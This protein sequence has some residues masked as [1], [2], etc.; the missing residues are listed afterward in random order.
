MLMITS[1]QSTF[2]SEVENGDDDDDA[3]EILELVRL[4][5]S[6]NHATSAVN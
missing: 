5:H 1:S 4:C 6:E 3:G 2:R